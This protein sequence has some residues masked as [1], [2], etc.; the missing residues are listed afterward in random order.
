LEEINPNV[1]YYIY[2][3]EIVR[4][5]EP[6]RESFSTEEEFN[7]AWEQ[8][9]NSLK[10]LSQEYMSASWGVDIERKLSEKASNS[11]VVQLSD[12]IKAIQGGENGVSLKTLSTAVEAL[13]TADVSI[14]ND[15]SAILTNADGQE[16]GRL[17]EAENTIENI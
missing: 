9:V 6:Y 14:K 5:R 16:S 10:T 1:F 11:S 4:T 2:E 12:E 8:W 17:V 7:A 15:I 3:E 13:K